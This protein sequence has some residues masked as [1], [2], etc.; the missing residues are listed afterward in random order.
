[1]VWD[2]RSPWKFS[3][4]THVK[5][6]HPPCLKRHLSGPS[7]HRYGLDR[8]KLKRLEQA[9]L[10]TRI[11]KG[12]RQRCPS[13]L[14]VSKIQTLG[15]AATHPPECLQWR[16]PMAAYSSKEVE[17]IEIHVLAHG[18][19]WDSR[20]AKLA[21]HGHTCRHTGPASSIAQ[22]WHT[23]AWMLQCV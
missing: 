11:S 18:S 8:Y 14:L 1:M 23:R 15:D 19:S 22:C 12:G 13:S 4:A 6:R 20:H 9:L 5:K 16:R 2:S 7:K 17:Q 10:K 3:E 21:M